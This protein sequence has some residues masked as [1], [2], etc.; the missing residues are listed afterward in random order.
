MKA[1]SKE[2]LSEVLKLDIDKIEDFEAS[3]EQIYYAV[4]TY[5]LERNGM[6]LGSFEC[7]CI[8]YILSKGYE[9]HIHSV[10]KERVV[11]K[12]VKG[13]IHTAIVDSSKCNKEL[14]GADAI[15][16]LSFYT[17]RE[18]VFT[19]CDYVLQQKDKK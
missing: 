1:I 3:E 12:L 4:R 16:G 17:R 18:A 2:L 14:Y 19:A 9:I 6:S 13:H 11:L 5:K 15:I 10:E 8:D 7:L